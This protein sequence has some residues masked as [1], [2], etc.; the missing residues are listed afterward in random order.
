M[1]IALDTNRYRD[2]CANLPEVVRVLQ[3][4]ERIYLPFVMLAELRAGFAAGKHGRENERVLNLFLNRSRV[5]P[6][7]ADEETTFHFARLYGQLRQQGTPIPAH[8]LWIA[9]L[10]TQ[11]G[12]VLCTRDAHF[13]HLPQIPRV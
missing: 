3:Q 6:L 7:F 11:H 2:F 13:Q 5:T 1:K 10:A 4:A 8:D 9:A 12:A